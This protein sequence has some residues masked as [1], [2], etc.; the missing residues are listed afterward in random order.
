MILTLYIQEQTAG[1]VFLLLVVETLGGWEEQ[2]VL[3]IK[4]LLQDKQAKM[5]QRRRVALDP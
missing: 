3:L 4:K 1:M 2:A 5:K